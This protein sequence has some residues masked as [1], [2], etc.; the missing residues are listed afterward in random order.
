MLIVTKKLKSIDLY[1][2]TIF[3]LDQRFKCKSELIKWLEK[4]I[5]GFKQ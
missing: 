1:R 4:I 5:S 2:A 3:H